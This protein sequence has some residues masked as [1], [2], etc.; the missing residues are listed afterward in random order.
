MVHW[1]INGNREIVLHCDI[2]Y[3][4]LKKNSVIQNGSSLII[5]EFLGI[6]RYLAFRNFNSSGNFFNI[7]NS[8]QPRSRLQPLLNWGH[9]SDSD[10]RRFLLREELTADSGL[11]TACETGEI[12]WHQS[13]YFSQLCREPKIINW[14]AADPKKNQTNLGIIKHWVFHDGNVSTRLWSVKNDGSL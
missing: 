3:L 8:P 6:F 2:R 12:Y 14:D 10:T 1:L 7:R 4:N 5:V 9:F 13:S 11:E